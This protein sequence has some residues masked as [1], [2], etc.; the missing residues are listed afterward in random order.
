MTTR[1]T[2]PLIAVC[3][4][5]VACGRTFADDNKA[6][7]AATAAPIKPA[8][9][10]TLAGPAAPAG[11]TTTG[12]APKDV[13]SPAEAEKLKTLNGY[14]EQGPKAADKL[15]DIEGY[16]ERQVAQ[17]PRPMPFMPLGEIGPAAKDAVP[18]ANG[19]VQGSRMRTYAVRCSM[20]LHSIHPG[21][22][23]MVPLCTKMLEDAGPTIRV[24][25]LGA[26]ADGGAEAVPGLI[27]ALK[28]EKACFWALIILRDPNVL[29]WRK[30]RS[31]RSSKP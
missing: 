10:T 31:R 12:A 16:V 1:I 28:N 30:T 11:P 23:I 7:P 8:A 5:L 9:P 22:K 20:R 24:R 14:I 29:Q 17:G 25:I 6:M 2:I 13:I 3:G 27:A 18:G 19:I 15:K 21:P 4:C 26:I